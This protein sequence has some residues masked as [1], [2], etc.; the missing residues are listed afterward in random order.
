M[1]IPS[2]FYLLQHLKSFPGRECP[3]PNYHSPFNSHCLLLLRGL[4]GALLGDQSSAPLSWP[5]M[6]PDI[7]SRE[8]LRHGCE[9]GEG[10]FRDTNPTLSNN[11]LK[12][13]RSVL[14]IELVNK[15]NTGMSVKEKV[16][17]KSIRTKIVF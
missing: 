7:S 5:I 4:Q 8:I 13:V 1:P 12:S 2:Y 9:K 14:W 11:H 16:R 15:Q 10:G 3:P 6:Y 17:R